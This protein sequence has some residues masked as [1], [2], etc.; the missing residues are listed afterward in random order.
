M[1]KLYLITRKDL[2]PGAQA[3]QLVHAAIDY[4]VNYPEIIKQWHVDS[5]TI[6]LLSVANERELLKLE[7]KVKQLNIT[8][9]CLRE[10][11]LDDQLTSISL[12]PS[13]TSKH[14]CKKLRLALT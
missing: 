1:T 11:D 13:E 3:S 4:S 12:E 5:N 2:E 9:V 10:P 6:V 7:N 8:H 14:F